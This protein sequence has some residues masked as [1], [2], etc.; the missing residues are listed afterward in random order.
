MW[1]SWLARCFVLQAAGMWVQIPNPRTFF[2][3]INQFTVMKFQ[4]VAVVEYK[5][6]KIH[7]R[8]L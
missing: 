3:F 6:F 7:Q 2:E 4:L 5:K 1:R 8:R